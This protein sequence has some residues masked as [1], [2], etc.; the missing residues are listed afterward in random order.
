[1][2]AISIYSIS[3]NSECT[4]GSLEYNLDPTDLQFTCVIHVDYMETEEQW[5]LDCTPESHVCTR[6]LS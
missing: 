2:S 4:H 5:D 1:L 6:S 3:L